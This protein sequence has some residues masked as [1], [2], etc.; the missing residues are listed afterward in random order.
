MEGDREGLAFVLKALGILPSPPGTA[1]GGAP[2]P[3]K[4]TRGRGEVTPSKLPLGGRR[5]EAQPKG[6][7]SPGLGHHAAPLDRRQSRGYK[8]RRVCKLGTSRS[9]HPPPATGSESTGKSLWG[10]PAIRARATVAESP[11]G[12]PV[13]AP[14]LGRWEPSLEPLWSHPQVAAA[15]ST[16]RAKPRKAH[17]SG[18]P[19][20]PAPHDP[21][22]G[23]RRHHG[24][25]GGFS[26][27][28]AGIRPPPCCYAAVR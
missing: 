21:A 18:L 20:G 26:A 1:Y 23:L 15:R 12:A 8:K 7:P 14:D 25:A 28:G 24:P 19:G 4:G 11:P 9:I 5:A 27:C 13:G 10:G 3:P 16:W 6:L 17:P 22:L 2:V